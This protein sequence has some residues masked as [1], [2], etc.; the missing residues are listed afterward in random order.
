MRKTFNS[1]QDKNNLIYKLSLKS[2]T[3]QE[4]ATE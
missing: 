2:Q 1:T 3:L 4:K